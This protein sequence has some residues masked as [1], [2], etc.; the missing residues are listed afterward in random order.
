MWPKLVRKMFVHPYPAP[1]VRH[2]PDA[3]EAKAV[4]GP[5]AP[6]RVHHDVARHHFP[7]GQ[8]RQGTAFVRLDGLHRFAEPEGNG[9]A[10]EVELQSLPCPDGDDG[11]VGA[12]PL[13]PF[14][15]ADGHGV[16]VDELTPALEQRHAVWPLR[17]QL[18]GRQ[19]HNR[20]PTRR[21]RPY[22]SSRTRSG[23]AVVSLTPAAGAHRDRGRPARRAA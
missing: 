10:P 21:S 6:G 22:L 11:L 15:V 16:V 13:L 4:G 1:F 17:W 8:R 9:Q 18:F 19:G 3:L 2:D 23:P 12:Y 7:A 14:P 20:S 5:L